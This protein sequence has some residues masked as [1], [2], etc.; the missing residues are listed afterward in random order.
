MRVI[1]SVRARGHRHAV[2]QALTRSA[3]R[4]RRRLLVV[5]CRKTR[6][7]ASN[8][9]RESPRRDPL[10][11]R[12]KEATSR[13]RE[14]GRDRVGRDVETRRSHHRGGDGAS[15]RAGG[16]RGRSAVRPFLTQEG[17]SRRWHAVDRAQS[18][19]VPPGGARAVRE[20]PGHDHGRGSASGESVPVRGVQPPPPGAAS[21]LP[22]KIHGTGIVRVSRGG[23]LTRPLPRTPPP[24]LPAAQV[25]GVC[26]LI[27]RE[28]DG[29]RRPVCVVSSNGDA[30]TPNLVN[31]RAMREEAEDARRLLAE[32]R[33]ETR[34]LRADADAAREHHGDLRARLDDARRAS[35][36]AEEDAARLSAAL[37]AERAKK[38]RLS[39]A[40]GASASRA[41][42]ARETQKSAI[43]AQEE[44]EELRV[45]HA[46]SAR[47]VARAE[48]E[49]RRLVAKLANLRVRATAPREE[50]EDATLE[51]ATE[52]ATEETL[53]S[54]SG[55]GSAARRRAKP[56][57]VAA[58]LLAAETEP[59]PSP[60]PSPWCSSTRAIRVRPGSGGSAGSSSRSSSGSPADSAEDFPTS[61][62]ARVAA[63]RKARA[64]KPVLGGGFVRRKVPPRRPHVV[65]LVSPTFGDP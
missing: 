56:S 65:A 58:A 27:K 11:A 15:P 49:N 4:A 33:A 52:A 51:A 28:I 53:E 23:A 9:T 50:T 44:L 16:P 12:A 38:K 41:R 61:P 25:T 24:P 7:S 48:A 54:S 2:E 60:S 32:S 29:K 57:E 55:R 13:V 64:D 45:A 3:R 46:R 40:L 30:S 17:I 10:R 43:R 63:A 20:R 34:K 1:R 14:G 22:G 47:D 59:S 19:R 42:D 21:A 26:R 35:R 37:D 8:S 18:L 36:R 6:P 39:D 31:S 62:P 5:T